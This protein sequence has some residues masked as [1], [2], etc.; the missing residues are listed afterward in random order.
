[1]ICNTHI[2]DAYQV[3]KLEKENTIRITKTKKRKAT[4]KVSTVSKVQKNNRIQKFNSKSKS[5]STKLTKKKKK[6]FFLTLLIIGLVFASVVLILSVGNAIYKHVYLYR[7]QRENLDIVNEHLRGEY[8]L[9]LDLCSFGR[10]N[11]ARISKDL[12]LHKFNFALISNSNHNCPQETEAAKKCQAE[13]KVIDELKAFGVSFKSFDYISHLEEFTDEY[14]NYATDEVFSAIATR[15]KKNVEGQKSIGTEILKQVKLVL[16]LVTDCLSLA[17]G[18]GISD[19]TNKIKDL[20][21]KDTTPVIKVLIEI[22]NAVTLY[23][24]VEDNPTGVVNEKS[25]LHK[26]VWLVEQIAQIIKYLSLIGVKLEPANNI[27]EMLESLL[28]IVTSVHSYSKKKN[29]NSTDT[30]IF[31]C[32]LIEPTLKIV[33]KILKFTK[34]PA[35]VR[36]FI[37]IIFKLVIAIKEILESYYQTKIVF[38][39]RDDMSARF[40][41]IK[42]SITLEKCDQEVKVFKFQEFLL[43]EDTQNDHDTTDI[44]SVRNDL[45]DICKDSLRSCMEIDS[46]KELDEKMTDGKEI[47]EFFEPE[48]F[49]DVARNILF[50]GP[51]TDIAPSLNYFGDESLISLGYKVADRGE[52]EK[53]LQ[54]N[55]VLYCRNCK[56][57]T[58][59]VAICIEYVDPQTGKHLEITG[60]DACGKY[61]DEEE[62]KNKNLKKK[63]SKSKFIC[64]ISL[65]FA[66][67]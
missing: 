11:S 36:A 5:Q 27:I 52:G 55:N 42:R 20:I 65:L 57:N 35:R 22:D 31:I 53:Y 30:G 48:L 28:E 47:T 1:M 14:C 41:E 17:T 19:V 32:G 29:V 46:Y 58:A 33:S 9:K 56:A 60:E 44:A 63:S 12:T 8:E 67:S 50:D 7:K 45:Y 40:N 21:S 13:S 59:I 6:F 51:I 66:R 26:F 49:K 23:K 64:K 15:T 39:D 61:P 3:S 10:L 62:I 24:K 25:L 34:V 54:M 4:N 16:G 2:I 38:K 37:D 18:L 43:D